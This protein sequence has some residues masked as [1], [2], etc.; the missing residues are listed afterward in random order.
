MEDLATEKRKQQRRQDHAIDK[1]SRLADLASNIQL[2]SEVATN[3]LRKISTARLL[4]SLTKE[5][6]MTDW[7]YDKK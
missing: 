1:W 6:D 4:S 2:D 5:L 3:E 7:M